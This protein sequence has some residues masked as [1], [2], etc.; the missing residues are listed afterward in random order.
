MTELKVLI[1]SINCQTRLTSDHYTNYLNAEGSLPKDRP[2]LLELVGR[3]LDLDEDCFRP[4]YVG[5][6]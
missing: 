5:R 1:A 2:R 4:V 6:Q 3:A